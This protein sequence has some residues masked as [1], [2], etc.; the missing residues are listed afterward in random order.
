MMWHTSIDRQRS[1]LCGGAVLPSWAARRRAR[2]DWVLPG[3]A[4]QLA[5]R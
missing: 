5:R 3:Q 1:A 2:Q 4:A